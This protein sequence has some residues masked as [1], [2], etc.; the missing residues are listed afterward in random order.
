M[1]RP[2]RADTVAGAG[3]DLVGDCRGRARRWMVGACRPTRDV[4]ISVARMCGA[5]CVGGGGPVRRVALRWF[6]PD[7]NKVYINKR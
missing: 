4:G 2:T 7:L 1:S 6:D 5:L 3:L